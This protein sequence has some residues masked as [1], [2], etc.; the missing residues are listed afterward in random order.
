MLSNILQNT[1]NSSP[2]CETPPLKE[3]ESPSP[4]PTPTNATKVVSPLETLFAKTFQFCPSMMTNPLNF[5]PSAISRGAE[6]FAR[7]QNQCRIN[8]MDKTTDSLDENSNKK[9][10]NPSD[11]KKP[12]HS[13]ESVRKIDKIAENLRIST[14]ATAAKNC[15]GDPLKLPLA[16]ATHSPP[17]SLMLKPQSFSSLAQFMAENIAENTNN[18]SNNTNNN[19]NN[20]C[21][22][23]P[24]CL[25]LGNQH[26]NHQQQQ[27]LQHQ[28][29]QHEQHHHH[30]LHLQQ[31]QQ[32]LHLQQQQQLQQQHQQQQHLTPQPSPTFHPGDPML[33]DSITEKSNLPKPSNSKLYATCFICHKQLSN[34]YNLRVHLETHQNVRYVFLFQSIYI[35]FLY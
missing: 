15:L 11:S 22:P 4:S 20:T 5:S 8:Q 32:H 27:Q 7:Y 28:Q 13:G 16:M 31:Q 33:T 21:M 2:K 30:Q 34:Q 17:T 1:S 25:L 29:Q 3:P 19:N 12:R 24:E 14:T 10:I 26:H 23:K 18:N 35:D 6:I 9:C